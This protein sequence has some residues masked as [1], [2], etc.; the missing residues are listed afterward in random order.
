VH[1]PTTG[2]GRLDSQR[3]KVIAGCGRFPQSDQLIEVNPAA[4]RYN[5]ELSA[6]MTPPS[7]F[8]KEILECKPPLTSLKGSAVGTGSKSMQTADEGTNSAKYLRLTPARTILGPRG[9]DLTFGLCL[10]RSP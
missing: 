1:D 4:A 10:Y 5:S 2:S 7:N 6:V 9:F 3:D 8:E